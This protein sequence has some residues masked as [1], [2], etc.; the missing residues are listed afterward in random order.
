MVSEARIYRAAANINS[1]AELTPYPWIV[2]SMNIL[3]VRGS[4]P[5]HPFRARGHLRRCEVMKK[6]LVFILLMI[7]FS[8]FAGQVG[9]NIEYAGFLKTEVWMRNNTDNNRQFLTS[10]KNTIDVAVEYEISD[11]WAFFV[12]PRYF[13][14]FAYDLRDDDDFDRNQ[15]KMGHTQ[16]QEWLRDCYFDYTSD[17]LDLRLGKQQVVWGQ[18]DIPILD[19]VMPWDLTNWFLPDLAD[20]RI[21][22]WMLK[23]EYSPQVNSTLQFLMIP[24]F[25]QSRVAPPKAPFGMT[26]Y[27]AFDDLLNSLPMALGGPAFLDSVRVDYDSPGQKLEN[28]TFGLRWRSM[29][30]N[31]E[32]TLNWLYG[33]STS[34]Y[35]Y[36]DF[37]VQTMTFGPFRIGV[38]S[39]RTRRHKRTQTA[40]FSFAKT[41]IEPGP[42][43]GITVKGE[44]AYVHKEPTYYGTPGAW[45]STEPSDKYNWGIAIEKNIV[46]NWLVSFQFLQF[47]TDRETS[48]A[49]L[50]GAKTKVLD[51]ATYG[52]LDKLENYYVLK[53]MTDFMHERLKPEVTCV[54]QEDGH[55]R[56][57]PKVIFELMD[58]IWLKLGYA[59]FF[60]GPDTNNGEFRNRDQLM[61]EVKYT[62]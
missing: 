51:T 23:A 50:T 39:Y 12:H 35:L 25:E 24:D 19:R 38:D 29:I 20:M 40:G 36:E 43:E 62:F 48:V 5:P 4:I 61:F 8:V 27:N 17:N 13:Y 26:A 32:Y 14:D 6:F 45:A 15:Y 53:V 18:M 21:P 9:D 57:I 56:I 7:P 16:R 54:V 59:H 58:N 1:M 31:L 55:G 52:V 41:F 28:S 11:D 47:V 44:L 3:K 33:F 10:L 46:K 60:G 22:L 30:G 37:R 42:F 34:A 49:P 2:Q